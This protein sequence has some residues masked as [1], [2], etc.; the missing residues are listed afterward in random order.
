MSGPFSSLGTWFVAATS[1]AI[2]AWVLSYIR[3]RW[4]R[5]KLRVEINLARG[6]VVESSVLNNGVETARRTYAR[7]IVHNRGRTLAENCCA[8]IDYL[9]RTNPATADYIF[10]TVVLDLKWSLLVQ[11]TTVF[12][13]PSLGHRLLDVGH[14]EISANNLAA[15][16]FHNFIFWIDAAIIPN[17]MVP[18]L[19]INSTYEMHIQVF[20]D[21]A[22]PA[23]CSCRV[24]VG[25]AY[26]ILTIV[27]CNDPRPRDQR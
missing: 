26:N 6:S 3:E 8:Y 2:A 14:T 20:A 10:R 16:T 12:H 15:G 27:P 22:A 19:I 11:A 23:G 9:K 18:E 24:T 25:N 4:N 17:R 1:G 21:N 5:P 13:I 7:L